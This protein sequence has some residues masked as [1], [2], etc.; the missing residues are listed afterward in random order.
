MTEDE[1]DL[2]R[3]IFTA[4]AAT[5]A[6]PPADALDPALLRALADRHVV[7]LDARGEIA[8]AHPFARPPGGATVTAHG[9]TWSG[10]CAWDAYGIQAA[11]GLDEP[12]IESRG[13]EAG[14]GVV[15]HVATPARHWWDD[16]ADT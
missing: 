15:F 16:I 14:P 2:R 8:M 6:P 4:F 10:N 3:T 5:G 7:V 13:V 9:M 12:G 11:L 1:L